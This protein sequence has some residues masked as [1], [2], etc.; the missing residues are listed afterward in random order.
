M[1]TPPAPLDHSWRGR[2]PPHEGAG[3]QHFKRF[4]EAGLAAP[5][6]ADDQGETWAGGDLQGGGRAD[7]AEAFY[8][9]G[10]Q[11][12]ADRVFRGGVIRLARAPPGRWGVELGGECLVAFERGQE[13]GFCLDGQGVAA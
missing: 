12:G 3:E 4:G 11:V 6:P 2:C 7:A 1:L 13:Q 5:V 8:G 10:A 9:Q